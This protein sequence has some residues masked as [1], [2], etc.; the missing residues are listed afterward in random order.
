MH[1][2]QPLHWSGM[3]AGSGHAGQAG[4]QNNLRIGSFKVPAEFLHVPTS[5]PNGPCND[6]GVYIELFDG[7]H[8]RRD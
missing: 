5:A 7:I 6:D 1:Q 4:S 8:D 2:R 3:Y